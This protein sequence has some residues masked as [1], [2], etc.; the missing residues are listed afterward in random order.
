MPKDAVLLSDFAD[1][2]LG[3][4]CEPCGRRGLYGVAGLIERHGDAR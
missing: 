1:Q 4:V 2:V 3:V